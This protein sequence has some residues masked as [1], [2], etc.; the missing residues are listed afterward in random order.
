MFLIHK[1]YKE[2]KNCP[3]SFV[4]YF[5]IFIRFSLKIFYKISHCKSKFIGKFNFFRMRLPN[6]EIFADGLM[7]PF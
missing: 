6:G 4:L 7:F 3:T 1:I 5:H 2:E